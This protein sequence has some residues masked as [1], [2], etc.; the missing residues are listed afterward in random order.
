MNSIKKI[1]IVALVLLLLG[2]IGSLI[3]FNTINKSVPVSEEKVIDDNITAVEISAD[4]E[5]VELMAEIRP[6]R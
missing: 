3:T 6:D 1:A 2:G 4:N 5:E